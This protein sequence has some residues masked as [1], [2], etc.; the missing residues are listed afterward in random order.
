MKRDWQTGTMGLAAIVGGV[1]LTG[2]VGLSLA[3]AA[4]ADQPSS[5]LPAQEQPRGSQAPPADTGTP[6]IPGPPNP[7]QA[8]S[9]P[10]AQS[11][12]DGNVAGRS[13]LSQPAP[14]QGPLGTP[15]QGAVAPTRPESQGRMPG[16]NPF[17]TP[18]TQPQPEAAQGDKNAPEK[19]PPATPSAEQPSK[20]G[21]PSTPSGDHSTTET[22]S[23]EKSATDQS[24][25]QT[26]TPAQQEVRRGIELIQKEKYEDALPHFE[27]ASKIDPSEGAAYFY[28]G[29]AQRMLNRYDDAINSF[30]KA[31]DLTTDDLDAQAE[32]YLRRGIVWFNKGEYGV[33]WQDFDDAAV[34]A[35]PND[36]R[37][38]FWKGLSQARLDKPLDAANSFAV[39]IEHDDHFG[40]AFVNL[41]LIYLKLD[42]PKKAIYCFDQAVRLDPHNATHYFKRGVAQSRLNRLDQAANSYSQ[43]LRLNPDYAEAYL[44]RSSVNRR[45]GNQE[46]ADK[47]RAAAIK[48][49]PD[50]EKQLTSVQ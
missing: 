28:K 7:F 13:S 30:T 33:A 43:A 17:D 46:Q 19:T 18:P 6:Q 47:D 42:E 29:V 1:L 50:I 36:P 34:F 5:N 23:G 11:G 9:A 37:P 2:A 14:V 3:K 16:P 31:I 10:G 21:T 48:I 8:R 24:S 22:P 25:D 41:G 27:E 49:N 4:P 15:P 38:D 12:T 45:L 20:E 26:Y 32:N 39:A 35:G 44:N 40:P